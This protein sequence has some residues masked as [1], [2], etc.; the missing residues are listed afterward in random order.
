[1]SKNKN[2]SNK[3]TNLNK[4][5]NSNVYIEELSSS[6]KHIEYIY[7]EMIISYL[8]DVFKQDELPDLLPAKEDYEKIKLNKEEYLKEKESQV[9]LLE[10]RN[11]LEEADPNIDY[12]ELVC[13]DYDD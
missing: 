4:N 10:S 2:N 11:S 8:K 13:F 5:N 9:K 3:F 12:E 7:K 6:G 1:M